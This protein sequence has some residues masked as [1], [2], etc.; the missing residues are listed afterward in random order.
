MG[1]RLV[2]SSLWAKEE[3][4]FSYTFDQDRILV[5]RSAGSDVCIP[6]T[7]VSLSHA[8]ITATQSHYTITDLDSTNG[9]KVNGELIPP[10]RGKRLQ[11]DDIIECGGFEIRFS[12]GIPV[13]SPTSEVGTATFARKMVEAALGRA[14][15]QVELPLLRV[16]A[17]PDQGNTLPLPRP[18]ARLSV[19]RGDESDLLL[20]DPD[21]SRS[22]IEVIAGL[23]GYE[24]EDLNSKNG[25]LI[26]GRSMSSRRLRHGDTIQLGGT[27]IQFEDPVDSVV[28]EIMEAP[29]EQ[30]AVPTRTFSIAGSVN[31]DASL[32]DPPALGSIS[33]PR[34]T[35]ASPTKKKGSGYGLDLMI[36]VLAGA[37]LALSVAGLVALLRS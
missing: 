5:G 11:S 32:P 17:G 3:P 26:A 13:A 29:D 1:V 9:T 12:A 15:K 28:R 36:Y 8:A 19:G 10:H 35:A 7:A 30:L 18:P 31:E 22:H 2:I 33:P 34:K 25:M 4:S 14:D 16:V 37:V 27:V 24:V 23:D 6:H 21:V 20:S